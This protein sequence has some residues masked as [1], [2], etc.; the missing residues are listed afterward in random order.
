[1]AWHRLLQRQLKRCLGEHFSA[2][3]EWARLLVRVDEAYRQSDEDRALLERSLELSSRELLQANSEL[4]AVF[5][6]IPDMLFRVDRSGT[7]LSVKAGASAALMVPPGTVRGKRIQDIP[8]RTISRLFEDGL[9]RA[10]AKQGLVTFDY[11]VPLGD[12][13]AYY[14]AR[15]IPRGDDGTVV[16]VRDITARKRDEFEIARLSRLYA[17]LSEANQAVA[18]SRSVG[19]MLTQVCRGA[20][21]RGGFRLA[22]IGWVGAGDGRVHPVA[23][24]GPAGGYFRQ[25]DISVD[26]AAPADR[27]PV[28]ISLQMERAV[29]ID[30]IQRDERA[31]LWREQA[32]RYGLASCG[33]FPIRKAGRIA[34]VLCVYA[35][36]PGQ[37]GGK[38]VRLLEEVA[39]D[40]SF[41]L[42]HFEAEAERQRVE[43]HNRQLATIVDS[44]ND[45]M[46]SH[47]LDDIVLTWNRGAAKTFG[48]AEG[49]MVGQTAEILVPPDHRAEVAELHARLRRGE[50]ITPFESVRL[51]NDG[52]EIQV[53]LAMSALHD[54]TGRVVGFATVARDI[55]EQKELA[56]RFLRAQR[57]ESVGKLASGLA[58]DLNNILTPIVMGVPLVRG[59]VPDAYTQMLIDTIE[60]SAG[61]G[62]QVIR[63]ILMFAR[64]AEHNKGPTQSR[65]LVR[66]IADMLEQTFPKSIVVQGN[67]PRD[68]WLV[69]IDATQFHQ[70][71][72]NL[73]VNARDAMPQGGTLTLSGANVELDANEASRFRE[74]K[75]G[76]Y[77]EWTIADTGDGISPENLEKIFE[78]FFT[79]K[80]LGKGTGLGLATVRS[81]VRE[82]G[83]FVSVTSRPG[84]GTRFC[85][86]LPASAESAAEERK[87]SSSLPA[88]RGETVLVVDDEFAVAQVIEQ[89]LLAHNYRVLTADSAAS[90]LVLFRE[91]EAEIELLLTDLIMPGMNG[92]ELIR[93][94]RSR[95][96]ALKVIAISGLL[97]RTANG[98]SPIDIMAD[99]FLHKPV[100]MDALLTQTAAV[101]TEKA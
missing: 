82:A 23:C 14:E 93:Q 86:H 41:A 25:I 33:V 88:G 26:P 81:I 87:P 22:W 84:E 34:G 30:D 72:M 73:C 37:F 57:L 52:Q 3:P 47:T 18:Q 70:V 85:V 99:A 53:A 60:A 24:E 48:Y 1:M 83:G 56:S 79:T 16:I 39:G 6:A 78:P 63:Q 17:V 77:V 59:K 8:D 92:T 5:E 58:H 96:P 45:A 7:I 90:A 50:T 89:A 36:M 54:A 49:E 31:G 65:H 74:A 43:A 91:H 38:E 12:Q 2:P 44:S 94:L 35:D 40:V 71:M 20:V 27:N 66:E 69:D 76:R 15:L 19:E 68:L 80:A 46:V 95:N 55:T 9:N 51:R 75:P 64:G 101:L 10:T 32:G 13:Y 100:T 62:A 67:L 21:E 11:V 98:A 97:D 61:R 4:R 42:D 29:V 28:G